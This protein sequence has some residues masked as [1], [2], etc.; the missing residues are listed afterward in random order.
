MLRQRIVPVL[1]H[2]ESKVPHA[3][4]VESVTLGIH[5]V[6][7]LHREEVVEDHKKN[8]YAGAHSGDE[9][10][11]VAEVTEHSLHGLLVV[12]VKHIIVAYQL[13]V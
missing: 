5:E 10:L 9:G 1:R 2:D 4:V 8:S 7:L 13:W 6:Y 11:V 12:P 3:R